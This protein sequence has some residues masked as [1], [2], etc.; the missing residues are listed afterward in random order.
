M[1][2]Q[3]LQVCQLHGV[4]NMT[5]NTHSLIQL[6]SDIQF[7]LADKSALSLHIPFAILTAWNPKSEEHDMAFNEAQNRLLA[8]DLSSVYFTDISGCSPSGDYEEAGF[9]AEISKP[10]AIGLAEKYHQNAIYW[11]ENDELHLV[12]VLLDFDEI[13][14]GR[15]SDKVLKAEE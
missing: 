9:L 11:V 2:R 14:I 7:K 13:T 15:F 5:A 12:P 4:R 1:T 6:Y 3:A 10:L 8:E